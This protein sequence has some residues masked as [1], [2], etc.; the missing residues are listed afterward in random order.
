MQLAAVAAADAKAKVEG[1]LARVQYTLEAAK[2]TR[3]VVEEARSKA[4]AKAT[5]LEVKLTSLLLQ[6]ETA[7][8]KF[9]LSNP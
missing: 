6:I 2:E 1:D 9:P 7:K 4:K 3:A 8:T 5:C